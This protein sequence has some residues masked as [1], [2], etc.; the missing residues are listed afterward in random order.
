MKTGP[1]YFE[2]QYNNRLSIPNAGEYDTRGVARSRATRARLR[3]LLDLAYGGSPR[4]RIDLFPAARPNAPIMSFIH[5]GFWRSRDKA[6]FTFIAEPFVAEGITVALV[7]YDLAPAVTVETIVKQMLAA[8]SWLYRHAGQYGADPSRLHVV[9]HSA[10]GHLAAMMAAADWADYTP[11]G[12]P[13]HLPANL[14]KGAYALS[15]VFDLEPLLQVSLNSEIRLD[16]ESVK[17]T[18]PIHYKPRRPVPIRT[19]VGALESDEFKRQSKL[20][21]QR[22]PHCVQGHME[23][24]GTNHL[25]M[26][27][28]LADPQSALHQ[29]VRAMLLAR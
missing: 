3:G 13:L 27:E 25:A 26:A 29:S 17:R 21:A 2:R 4:E 11:D 1:E 12:R 24:P 18:S 22:W 7:E 5:G 19:A 16:E 8:H 28:V 23:V 20:I 9:G 6:E 10:G 15:G 14:V